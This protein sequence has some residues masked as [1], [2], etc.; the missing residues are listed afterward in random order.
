MKQSEWL[1]AQKVQKRDSQWYLNEEIERNDRVRKKNKP[2]TE[3]K[4]LAVAMMKRL[5]TKQPDIYN[6]NFNKKYIREI[7][8]IF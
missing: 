8:F 7:H 4:D 1:I 2:E 5:F 6:F 3:G